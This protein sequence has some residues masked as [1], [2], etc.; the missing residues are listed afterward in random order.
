M[1]DFGLS[2]ESLDS[3]A[4]EDDS[5][6]ADFT[7]D[8]TGAFKPISQ[9]LAGMRAGHYKVTIVWPDPSK[10]P[11]EAQKMMGTAD[12]GPDLLLGKYSLKSSTS[13]TV[14]ITDSTTALP[15]FAL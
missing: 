12:V 1:R 11:T 2:S 4:L 8:S 10:K 9:S 3:L 5:S 6:F 14:D 13:L 15:P 7:A